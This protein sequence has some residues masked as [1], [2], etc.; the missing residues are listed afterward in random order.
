MGVSRVRVGSYQGA[1]FALK[2]AWKQRVSSVSIVFA[3]FSNH[4]M[5]RRMTRNNLYQVI[6]Y[7]TELNQHHFLQV[8]FFF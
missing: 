5:S 3:F 7:D 6:Q 2:N 4:L 1:L 8:F